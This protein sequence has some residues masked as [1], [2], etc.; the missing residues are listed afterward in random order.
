MIL[1]II[2]SKDLGVLRALCLCVIKSRY[3][4]E[5]YEYIQ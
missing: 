5:L 2:V 4:D 1:R 3:A